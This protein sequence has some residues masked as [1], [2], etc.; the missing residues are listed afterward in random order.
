MPAEK[1][2]FPVGEKFKANVPSDKV[3]HTSQSF[4]SASTGLNLDYVPN[5]IYLYADQNC[6]VRF[7]GVVATAAA[8]SLPI[9]KNILYGPFEFGRGG[10][11]L[12]VIRDSAD[13]TLTVM[14]GYSLAEND[15][16]ADP[17]T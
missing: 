12:Q 4:S 7:D 3:V 16:D 9:V 15:L 1:G 8:P 14:Y 13:G 11:Q 2:G 10:D 6:W 17:T 5:K